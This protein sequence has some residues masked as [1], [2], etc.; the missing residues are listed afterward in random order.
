VIRTKSTGDW[1]HYFT[2]E[3]VKLLKRA[4]TPYME[5]IGYDFSDWDLNPNP[6][7]ERT[8]ILIGI[9]AKYSP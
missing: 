5:L 1:R 4:Y 8:R 3:D 9:D 2:E 6:V 7:I